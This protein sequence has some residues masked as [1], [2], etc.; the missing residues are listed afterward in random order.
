MKDKNEINSLLKSLKSHFGVI[1][2]CPI[3]DQDFE[4]KNSHFLQGKAEKNVIHNTCS[5][6]GHSLIFIIENTKIGVALLGLL[7][8]LSLKDAEKFII[9]NNFSENEL[10]DSYQIINFKQ[11]EFIKEIIKK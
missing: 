1:K 11:K 4:E 7:S 5:R 9:K 2:K 8:D 3:C 6:C 10:L